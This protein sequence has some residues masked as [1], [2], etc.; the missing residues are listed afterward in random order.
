MIIRSHVF[1]SAYFRWQ[2]AV[3][4]LRTGAI[5]PAFLTAGRYCKSFLPAF[6]PESLP[7]LRG[8]RRVFPKASADSGEGVGYSRKLA[9]TPRTPSGK[10][11]A[12]AE[13]KQPIT[14]K[15]FNLFKIKHLNNK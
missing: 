6:L 9:R 4:H 8:T 13:L 12:L 7:G 10:P 1:S 3:K 14:I 5:K 2:G 11:E 15:N